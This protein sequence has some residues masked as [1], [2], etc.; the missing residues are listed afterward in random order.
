MRYLVI[1]EQGYVE[2]IIIW[3]GVSRYNPKNKTLLLES[4]APTGAT[5]GWQLVNG[6]WIAPPVV[7]ETEQEI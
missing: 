2:N 6:E 1:N 3:D 4:E 7:E 5:F